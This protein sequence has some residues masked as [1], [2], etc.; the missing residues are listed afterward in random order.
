MVSDTLVAALVAGMS[1][2]ITFLW[3]IVREERKKRQ[4]RDEEQADRLDELESRLNMLFRDWYGHERDT[5][6]GH[7]EEIGETFQELYQKMDELRTEL[8]GNIDE[9]DGKLEREIE[10]IEQ[11]LEVL[12]E[13]I[14]GDE[15]DQ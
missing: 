1:G 12:E 14:N 15:E 10:S 9:L 7:K 11:R 2:L 4:E 3:N 8:S 6:P 5:D 13:S